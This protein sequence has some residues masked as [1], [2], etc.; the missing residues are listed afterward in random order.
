MASNSYN[1]IYALPRA[2]TS[3]QPYARSFEVEIMDAAL[4]FG[5]FSFVKSQEQFIQFLIFKL[6]SAAVCRLTEFDERIRLRP[7]AAISTVCC[8]VVL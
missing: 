3:A 6:I 4:A 5:A 7:P 8:T 2:D 1:H